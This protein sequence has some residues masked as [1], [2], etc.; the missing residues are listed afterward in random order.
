MRPYTRVVPSVNEVAPSGSVSVAP[1]GDGDTPDASESEIQE[2]RSYSETLST[3][4]PWQQQNQRG[5]RRDRRRDERRR[6]NSSQASTVQITFILIDFRV[7][8]FAFAFKTQN[9]PCVSR[10]KRVL[11]SDRF[12]FAF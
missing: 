12:Q 11:F 1:P 8:D 10:F 5:H 7:C 2:Q 6:A 3:E 9:A 4:G